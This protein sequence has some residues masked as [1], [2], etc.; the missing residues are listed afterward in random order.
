[1]RFF[2][3]YLGRK[4]LH[5]FPPNSPPFFFLVLISQTLPGPHTAAHPAPVGQL[6]S[7]CH[8]PHCECQTRAKCPLYFLRTGL[9]T[10]RNEKKKNEDQ[11]KLLLQCDGCEIIEQDLH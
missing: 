8:Q 10:L 9:K 6:C 3:S 4:S 2:F 11:Q 1:M 7:V 5:R